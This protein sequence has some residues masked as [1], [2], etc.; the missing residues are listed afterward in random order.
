MKLYPNLYLNNLKEITIELLRKNNIKGLILDI[1][2]TLIDFDKKLLEGCEEWCDNLKAQ[3]IKMCILSNTN[4]QHIRLTFITLLL[5][6]NY[7]LF[8][9]KTNFL[10]NVSL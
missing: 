6:F 9:H 4:K 1:D 2:N 7:F 10:P 8:G 3:G 5:Y